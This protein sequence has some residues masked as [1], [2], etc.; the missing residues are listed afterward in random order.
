LTDF[1]EIWHADASQSSAPK[2]LI[3]FISRFKKS[4]MAATAILK[5]QKIA[6][7]PQQN[8]RF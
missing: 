1:D 7:Y 2:K 8:D 6:L 5:I 3:K 4:K